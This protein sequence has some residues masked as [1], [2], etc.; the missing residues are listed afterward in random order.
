[1]VA[2]TRRQSE[3]TDI[4]FS[5]EAFCETNLEARKRIRKNCV[6]AGVVG[7]CRSAAEQGGRGVHGWWV[8]GIVGRRVGIVRFQ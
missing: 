8:V 7:A 4:G 6:A 5:K 3:D 2:W 1:M